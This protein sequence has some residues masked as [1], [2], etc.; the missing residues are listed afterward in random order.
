MVKTSLR[1]LLMMLLITG[2]AYPLLI[3]LVAQAAM[4]HKANGSFISVNGKTVGSS[5]IGQKF[6]SEKYFWGRPS[7][8]DYNPLNSGGSNLGAGSAV[9]KKQVEERRA[10]LGKTN[11][12]SDIPSNLLFASGS[13]LD[14][15]ITVDAALFQKERVLKSRGYTGEAAMNFEE[16]IDR[17]I[18]ERTFGFL[19]TPHINVLELNL[20]LDQLQVKP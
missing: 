9:L 18:E 6:E 4:Y 5:L 19:G 13:G 20:A 17:L 1:M 11:G 8:V 15:H 14:P 10:N 16:L 2:I 7:A 3:T 12:F